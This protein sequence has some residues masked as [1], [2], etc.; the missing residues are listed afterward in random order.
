MIAK[1][2]HITCLKEIELNKRFVISAGI[3]KIDIV[4][5]ILMLSGSGISYEQPK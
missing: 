5:S 2:Y 1:F 4:I 3:Y